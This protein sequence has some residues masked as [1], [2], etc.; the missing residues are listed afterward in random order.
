MFFFYIY[1]FTHKYKIYQ[2]S[3]I[4]L[5]LISCL[6]TGGRFYFLYFFLIFVISKKNLDSKFQLIN[7]KNIIFFFILFYILIS[8][9]SLRSFETYDI[10]YNYKE[11]LGIESILFEDSSF[12]HFENI[13]NNFLSFIIYSTHSLYFYYI[14][15]ATF[16]FQQYSNGGYTFNLLYR[17]INTIFNTEFS[18]ITNYF[19]TDPT[20]GRYST[21]ARDLIAD[22]GLLGLYILYSFYAFIFGIAN[23]LKRKYSSFKILYYWLALFFT[24]S[25][26][27][28]IISSG[29]INLMFLYSVVFLFLEVNRDAKY[30]KS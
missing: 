15:Y 24:L 20:I 8:S 30:N 14:H 11:N 25:P 2:Y 29:F 27:L 26:H 22:F 28:N 21:F 6:I 7:F 13:K 18:T 5:S 12:G 9:F 19:G 1:N 16:E 17:I 3:I 10:L 4:L 23:S